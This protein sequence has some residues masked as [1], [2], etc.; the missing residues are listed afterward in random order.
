MRRTLQL[1]AVLTLATIGLA[2]QSLASAG[3]AAGAAVV[4]ISPLAGTPTALPGTQISFLGASA[5]LAQLDH[6]GRLRAADGTADTCAPTASATGASFLP[7][8]AVRPRRARDRPRRAG[9]APGGRR[10]ALSDTF[11]IAQPGVVPQTRVP[12]PCRARPADVQTFQSQPQLHP[13]VVTVHAGRRRGQRAR[14]PVRHAVPRPRPVG[15]DDL[16]QRRQPRLVPPGARRRRRG[17]PA[18]ADLPRQ[19]RP[20][21]VAGTHAV[22]RLRPRRGR[23]RQLQLQDR[24]RRAGRQRPAGRRARVPR[25]RPQ[26]SAYVLAYSPVQTNLLERRRAGERRS[27]ST[28]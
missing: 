15:A 7:E 13:P 28:G 25:S 14:L 5:G 2:A 26:G 19:E 11:T 20:D 18:H 4:T 10:I 8:Q 23:D 22:A 6:R 12:R 17:R 9:S 3:A 24:R 16:R 1:L 27:R 21:L